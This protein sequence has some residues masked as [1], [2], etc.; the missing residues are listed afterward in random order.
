MPSRSE[1]PAES[2]H[3][4]LRDL[5]AEWLAKM[6]RCSVQSRFAEGDLLFEAGSTATRIYL[7]Q[8]GHVALELESHG[9]PVPVAMLGPGDMLVCPCLSA[10]RIWQYRARAFSPVSTQSI[11]AVRLRGACQDDP[12]FGLEIHRR[13][14]CAV[15][16]QL[17]ATRRQVADVSEVALDSQRFALEQFCGGQMPKAV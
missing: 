9:R 1:T 13:L 2:L 6:G 10:F 12:R 11:L 15:V 14:L 5:P 16:D 7:L 17:E 4:L 8:R 3:P